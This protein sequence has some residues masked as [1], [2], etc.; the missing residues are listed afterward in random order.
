MRSIAKY[1]TIRSDRSNNAVTLEQLR[2]FIAVAERQHLT[3]AA[4]AV[5]LTPSAVS[6]AIRALEDRHRVAL[7]DRVGRGIRLTEAGRLFL[8]EAQAILDRVATAEGMLTD[9][10]NLT[11]GHLVIGASQTMASHHLPRLMMA[12]HDAYPGLD[13]RLVTG[14]TE[15]VVQAVGEG[16]FEIGFVEG[17][18]DAPPVERRA[19][20]EDELVALVGPGHAWVGRRRLKVA[21]ICGARWVLREPGSGTRASFEQ[22]LDGLGIRIEALAVALELPSNEAMLS[23][24]EGGGAV[25][26]MSLAAAED[27]LAARRVMRADLALPRRA[28]AMIRHRERHATAAMTAF[29][30][31]V[32][33]SGR[34]RAISPPA[35]P[36]PRSRP[37]TPAA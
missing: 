2:I 10:A 34:W 30:A 35:P 14:N 13:M 1:D 18:F 15:T 5:H 32:L 20:A 28:L 6:A 25:A 37:E 19:M 3:R 29:E 23:A 7:F 11:S 26:V 36:P 27:A 21:D 9:L 24:V 16:R 8:G 22:F 4:E 12:F 17:P 31:L 33:R